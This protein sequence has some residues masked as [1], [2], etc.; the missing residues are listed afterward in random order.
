MTKRIFLLITA[1]LLSCVCLQA[2]AQDNHPFHLE[3]AM[4]AGVPQK[5]LFPMGV[6]IGL[7][8]NLTERL[9]VQAIGRCESF[10]PKEA[11]TDDYNKAFNLG[12]GLGY[13]LCP[14]E[15]DGFGS[16][17]LRGAV[18]TTVGH[19]HF[20]NTTASIGFYFLTNHCSLF[21]P[22]IGIGFNFRPSRSAVSPNLYFPYLSLGVRF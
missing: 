18:T 3:L 13:V 1:S 11:I 7:S 2:Q 9:S 6:N 10:I 19:T 17:E 20:K 5:R 12:G 22:I 16:I 4:E 8:Y 21:N 15:R 14:D